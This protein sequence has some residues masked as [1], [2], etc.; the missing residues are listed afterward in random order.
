MMIQITPTILVGEF[1][2]AI[3]P[4][5][6]VALLCAVSKVLQNALNLMIEFLV[7]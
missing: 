6:A 7:D 1:T 4:K 5:G 3:E 2:E